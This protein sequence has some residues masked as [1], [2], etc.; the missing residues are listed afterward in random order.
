MEPDINQNLEEE[1]LSEKLKGVLQ[2]QKK[3]IKNTNESK[4]T[5]LKEKSEILKKIER[6]EAAKIRITQNIQ[7]QKKFLSHRIL[8]EN[9][10]A[11]LPPEPTLT[12]QTNFWGFV[13][14]INPNQNLE[15]TLSITLFETNEPEELSGI[16]AEIGYHKAE[17]PLPTPEDLRDWPQEKELQ[18]I[19]NSGPHKEIKETAELHSEYYKNITLE[20]REKA[21]HINKVRR[22]FLRTELHQLSICQRYNTRSLLFNTIHNYVE[23]KHKKEHPSIK[24]DIKTELVWKYNFEGNSKQN[25]GAEMP[26]K[27]INQEPALSENKEETALPKKTEKQNLKKIFLTSSQIEGIK[28]LQKHYGILEKSLTISGYA[29][30]PPLIIGPSGVGK[31]TILRALASIKETPLLFLDTASWSLI[32]AKTEPF[33]LDILQQFVEKNPKGIIAIDECDKFGSE[34]SGNDWWRNV[35]GEAMAIIEKRTDNWGNW[36]IENKRKF[37]ENFVT[38]GM[39]TWQMVFKGNSFA[40]GEGQEIYQNEEPDFKYLIQSKIIPEELLARFSN[41]ILLKPQNKKDFRDALERIHSEFGN[42]I[43][44]IKLEN[45]CDEA[46]ESQKNAR[47]IEDYITNLLLNTIETTEIPEEIQLTESFTFQPPPKEM[48]E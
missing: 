33:T 7:L 45:L 48:L 9:L 11:D 8:C 37:I 31:T 27:E 32:N 28:L 36:K 16:H 34:N 3:S 15:S 18:I 40:N 1:G 25:S 22:A 30:R 19:I 38:I 24:L 44:D 20:N 5:P 35:R 46:V 6:L 39:G 12:N 21:I 17:T 43:T 10:P 2:N 14:E 26:I 4:F 13:P 41:P 47:W 29:T 42:P 23:T